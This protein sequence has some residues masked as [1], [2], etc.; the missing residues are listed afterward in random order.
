MRNVFFRLVAVFT[1]AASL[2]TVIPFSAAAYENVYE[3]GIDGFD[4]STDKGNII[5]YPNESGAVRTIKANEYNFRYAKL[6]I[7]NSEGRIIEAGSNLFENSDTV[8]GSPQESVNI[9]KGGFMVAFKSNSV[10]LNRAYTAVMEGAMLYNATMSVIYDLKASYNGNT[11]KIEYD[12]PK[13]PNANAKKYLFVGNSST[14][15]NGTPIKFKGLA[16]AAGV[17]LDVEYC[18]FGSAYLSEFANESHERGQALRSKLKAKKYDYVVLQD[19]G[20]ATYETTKPQVDKLLPLIKENG[21]E[22]LLY[23]RY[24]GANNLNDRLDGAKIHHENYTKLA[25]DYSLVCAPAADAF[26]ICYSSNPEIDLYADDNS[27]HSKE[28][29][30][31]VAC[32]WL[33]TYLGIDPRGNSYTAELDGSVVKTLQ[34]IA[35]QACLEG[36]DYEAGPKDT[37]TDKNGDIYENIAIGKEYTVSGTPYTAN[38]NWTDTDESGK[39]LGKLTNGKYASSGADNEIGAYS[40]SNNHVITVDMGTI[41]NVRAIRTDLFGNEDWGIP[42]PVDY[43]ITISI[44]NDG[45]HFM[46]IGQAEKLPMTSDGDWQKGISMLELGS[47]VNARYIRLT[48]SE[49]RFYWSSEISVYGEIFE[50]DDPEIS[51]FLAEDSENQEQTQKSNKKLSW[52]YWIIGIVAVVFTAG[53]AVFISKKKK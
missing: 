49:S 35:Y 29:S 13:A 10:E 46:D 4:C 16:K 2:G 5:V 8:T 50:N 36:Y 52:L 27:H 23:M 14:Y 21:A 47:P 18:T 7:F 17:E 48:F 15:F 34:Q 12:S 28:G 6:M 30:Y 45:T 24:S 40:G 26:C 32:V 41:A 3:F 1:L 43:N 11:L 53:A 9:P 22:A 39:P 31:L 19:A 37:Y 42:S 33:Q 25:S 51:K 44:S 38:A 20:S